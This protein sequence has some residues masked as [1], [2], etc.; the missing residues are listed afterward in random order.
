MFASQQSNG[1]ET[2]ANISS[3]K[4]TN[5]KEYLIHLINKT[6]ARARPYKQRE[7]TVKYIRVGQ[8]HQRITFLVFVL[9]DT[10]LINPHHSIP[11]QTGNYITR[12]GIAHIFLYLTSV[13]VSHKLTNVRQVGRH[14]ILDTK[15]LQFCTLHCPSTAIER[16]NS[17]KG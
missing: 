2:L 1:V 14:L 10:T 8:M 9:Y 11:S 13:N 15:D 4:Q 12:T 16:L 6:R 17:T 3:F 7:T 5:G